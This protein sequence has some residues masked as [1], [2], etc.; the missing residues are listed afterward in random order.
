MRF[1]K[2]PVGDPVV[3]VRTSGTVDVLAEPDDGDVDLLLVGIGSMATTAMAAAEK[4]AA[5]GVRVRVVDPVWALPVSDDLVALARSRRAGSRSSRTTS[6]SAASARRS[7]SP[8]ATPG[9]RR[10]WTCSASPRS[11]SQHGSR[12]QILD[13]IG[14]TPDAVAGRLRARLG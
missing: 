12:G 14:L 11:S 9:S 7:S 8:C 1:P 4:L 2:G 5:E 6:S 10:R 3:A 13:G